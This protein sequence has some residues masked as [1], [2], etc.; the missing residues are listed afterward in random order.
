MSFIFLFYYFFTFS[1]YFS[2]SITFS[3]L[4]PDILFLFTVA[5]SDLPFPVTTPSGEGTTVELGAWPSRPRPSA[6]SN[7]AG[8]LQNVKSNR[9]NLPLSQHFSGHFANCRSPF[10]P[11]QLEEDHSCLDL[12]QLTRESVPAKSRRKLDWCFFVH[13]CRATARPP[14]AWASFSEPCVS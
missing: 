7:D 4:S 8:I 6:T 13:H 11:T 1:N 9:A 3:L 10:S 5:T 14:I 2:S 12:L